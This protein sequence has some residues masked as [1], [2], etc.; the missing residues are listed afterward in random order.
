MRSGKTISLTILL[1]AAVLPLFLSAIF[2]G[3]RIAIRITMLR[4]LDEDQVTTIRIPE[5]DFKWYE[6]NRE[7]LV[8][9]KMFDVKSIQ[10]TDGV[11]EVTG[12]FDN[13]ETELNTML[14]DIHKDAKSNRDKTF[15]IFQVCLGLISDM[16]FTGNDIKQRSDPGK[17]DYVFYDNMLFSKGFFHPFFTPPRA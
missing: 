17:V 7:I 3:G 6:E 1:F 15:N 14:E 4:N 11:Y 2:L 13:M 9:G 12:L 8:D 16:P 10:L 5:K